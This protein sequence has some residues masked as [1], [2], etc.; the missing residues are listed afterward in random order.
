MCIIRV[1]SNLNVNGLS[2]IDL[3]Y[4]SMVAIQLATNP[5]VHAR[6]NHIEIDCHLT[7]DYISKGLISTQ[8]TSSDT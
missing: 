3:F 8:F 2:S 4:D 6:T 7:R 1:L 5:I